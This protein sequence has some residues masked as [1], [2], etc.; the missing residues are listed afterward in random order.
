MLEEIT[1]NVN[2]KTPDDPAKPL[3]TFQ[4]GAALLAKALQTF[5]ELA[6]ATQMI[7]AIGGEEAAE[8]GGQG[9]QGQKYNGTVD[10]LGEPVEIKEGVGDIE[11]NKVY[12][13]PDGAVVADAQGKVMG[14]IEDG[15]FVVIDK[16]QAAKME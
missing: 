11:G 15:K 8:Q 1:K 16:D 4:S 13:S 10:F 9:G 12:V 7:A 3:G 5:P 6:E 14:R 2:T